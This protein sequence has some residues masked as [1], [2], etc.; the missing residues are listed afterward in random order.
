MAVVL[1]GQKEVHE[2]VRLVNGNRTIKEFL[3][4]YSQRFDVLQ[5][6]CMWVV[7]IC[8]VQRHFK[9]YILTDTPL[10]TKWNPTAFQHKPS[11]DECSCPFVLPGSN[12]LKKIQEDAARGKVYA[13]RA[14]EP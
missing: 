11:L 3:K 2:T 4:R 7:Y 10:P 9:H 14:E 6:L 1:E 12:L 5:E 13:N 8:R